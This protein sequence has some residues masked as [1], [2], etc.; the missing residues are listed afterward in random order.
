MRFLNNNDR[1]LDRALNLFDNPQRLVVSYSIDLP[2]GP[3][4]RYLRNLGAAGR[5]VSGWQVSGIYT[6][7]SGT[8]LGLDAITNL[9]GSFGGGSR[10]PVPSCGRRSIR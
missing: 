8:P 7:Q 1:S 5:L 6:A 3:G 9:T 10:P 4:Q 2:F